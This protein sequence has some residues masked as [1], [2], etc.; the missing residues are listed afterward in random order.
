MFYL[1]FMI[2]I[3]LSVD[4]IKQTMGRCHGQ[5]DVQGKEI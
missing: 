5:Q 1:Y 2:S 3:R 4:V